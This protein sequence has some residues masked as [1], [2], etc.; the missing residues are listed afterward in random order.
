VI[1]LER[2][3]KEQ[4]AGQQADIPDDVAYGDAPPALR[5]A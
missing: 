2:A 4:A 1:A 5:L 3:L